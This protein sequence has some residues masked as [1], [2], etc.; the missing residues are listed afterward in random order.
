MKKFIF[1]VHEK[2]QA[3]RPS[4]VQEVV[5]LFSVALELL[6]GSENYIR[7]EAANLPKI[8]NGPKGNK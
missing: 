7:S 5:R 6:R 1:S 2:H 4:S 8:F 3:N